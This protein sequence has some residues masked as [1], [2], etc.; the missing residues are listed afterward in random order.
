[1]A[2]YTKTGD[3]GQTSLFD[4]TRVGK[5]NVRVDAYGTVDELNSLLGVVLSHMKKGKSMVVRKELVA[6]QH[7]LLEIGSALA[8]PGGMPV[9]GL[10]ARV[11]DFEKHIDELTSVLPPLHNFVLPG[12]SQ[13]GALLHS[14]R[15]VC[16]R[17]ER[18]IVDLMQTEAVDEHVV[19]YMNRLSDLLF[20]MARHV[21]HDENY[22]DIVWIK[23]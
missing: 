21:N 15:T 3:K 18:R 9:I 16:R 6:I 13:T 19:K 5:N 17:A 1:M 14:A 23:K 4:G 11:K 2:I 7:D 20:T 10:D 8:M 12:G 22:Q